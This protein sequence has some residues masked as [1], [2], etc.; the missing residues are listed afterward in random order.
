MKAG[1]FLSFE[2]AGVPFSR[3][4][5]IIFGWSEGFTHGDDRTKVRAAIQE[6]LG[7]YKLP[8]RGTRLL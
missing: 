8:L 2:V 4:M 3:D 5:P 1:F 6:K 7:K